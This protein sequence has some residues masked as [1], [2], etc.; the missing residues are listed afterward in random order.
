MTTEDENKCYE[1]L[2]L[3]QIYN[4]SGPELTVATAIVPWSSLVMVTTEAFLGPRLDEHTY[5]LVIT[6]S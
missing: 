6:D 1:Y 3:Q 5:G 4:E 2:Q